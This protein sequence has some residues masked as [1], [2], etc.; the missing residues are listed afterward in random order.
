MVRGGVRNVNAPTRESWKLAGVAQSWE[1][2]VAGF[3]ALVA[4]AIRHK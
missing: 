1:R 4:S 3:A 2:L